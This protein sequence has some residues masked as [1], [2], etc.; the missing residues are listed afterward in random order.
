MGKSHEVCMLQVGRGMRNA[1][2]GYVERE[3]ALLANCVRVS[4]AANGHLPQYELHVCI[5]KGLPRVDD[6]MEVGVVQ[7]SDK[8]HVSPRGGRVRGGRHQ[9]LEVEDVGVLH[10]AKQPAPSASRVG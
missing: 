4:H 1:S 7:A 10:E 6:T 9:I 8:V 3:R 2:G 5:G